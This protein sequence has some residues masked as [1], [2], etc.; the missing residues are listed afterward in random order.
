MEVTTTDGAS[1]PSTE[2]IVAA[3]ELGPPLE[4]ASPA[5]GLT[6]IAKNPVEMA[7]SQAA[8]IQ[9][10]ELRIERETTEL[11]LAQENLEHS[12][13]LKIKTAG[14]V[15]LV[16]RHKGFITYY[17]KALLALKQGYFVIPDLPIHIVAVR[18]DKYRPTHKKVESCG[19]Q[20]KDEPPAL[21]PAGEGHYVDPEVIVARNEYEEALEGGKSKTVRTVTAVDLAVPDFPFKA[22]RPQVLSELHAAQRLKLFDAIGVYPK[23]VRSSKRD[24]MLIG[25]ITT[26]RERMGWQRQLPDLR[27]GQRRLSFL[28]KWWLDLDS[29]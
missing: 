13:K 28:L 24:P 23:N 3:P 8:M 6:V 16:S 17:E 27:S 29:L 14:W 10:I 5:D 4:F 20:V 18:T 21:L 19:M 22:V 9:R 2:L 7:A 26:Q 1:D 11:K 25:V 15:R 12:K